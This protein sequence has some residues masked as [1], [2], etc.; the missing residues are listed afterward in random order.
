MDRIQKNKDKIALMI[1]FALILLV[2]LVTFF[3][4]SLKNKSTGNSSNSSSSASEAVAN[5]PKI[6]A[7]ELLKKIRA[8]ENF[9]LIDVRNNDN[10]QI[11]HIIDSLNF[12]LDSLAGS[13]LGVPAENLIVILAQDNNE[14]LQA[15]QIMEKK[16]FQKISV[17]SGDISTWKIANGQTVTWGNPSS[18][19]DNSKI[20]YILPEDLKKG[21]D[22]KSLD[23]ILDVRPAGKFSPHIPGAVNIPLDSLERRRA[24]IPFNKETIIYGETEMDGFQAGVKLYDMGILAGRVLRGGFP[25]W[26]AKGFP[27]QQ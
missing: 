19:E 5:Y 2:A 10:F 3:R 6:S 22:E 26:Q 24:E 4:P 20:T 27:T 13:D 25:A 23:Y 15:F 1:G 9:S 18:F 7:E 21:L 16:G 12:P 11:E 17:L 14:A 8:K